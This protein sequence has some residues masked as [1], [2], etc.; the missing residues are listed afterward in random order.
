MSQISQSVATNPSSGENVQSAVGSSSTSE[1]A[2]N[3]F[4]VLQQDPGNSD[5]GKKLDYLSN[6]IS[7]MNT[8]LLEV[9]N[10]LQFSQA[11][12]AE[13]KEAISQLQRDV[14]TNTSKISDLQKELTCERKERLKL[15]ERV[16]HLEAQSRRDNLLFDGVP[17]PE[18][19]T[20]T[21]CL[22]T[23]FH[24]L[25]HN[26]SIPDARQMKIVRCHRNGPKIPGSTRPRQI[27]FKMFWFGDREKIWQSRRKLKGS[28]IWV[29]EDFPKEIVQRRYKLQP[30][31]REAKQ[32]KKSAFISVDKLIVEGR[33]YTVDTLSSL[34][35]ELQPQNVS[36]KSNGSITAFYTSASPLS[37]FYP[38]PVK[39]DESGITF[40]TSEHF[41]QYCKAKEFGDV[42][43][44][45]KIKMAK[46]PLEAY[47]LGRKV[48]NY[49]RSQWEALSPDVMFRVCKAKYLQ[50][51]QLR[52]FLSKTGD[53]E[54]VEASPFDL[55]WGVGISLRNL[56][57][58]FQ[59]DNWKGKNWMGKVLSKVREQL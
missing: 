31:L 11:E 55:F 45:D 23:V 44:M 34:P 19:E 1:E 42:E 8:L 47:R 43:S 7:G 16:I 36:T 54:L 46:S 26:M 35:S 53:T 4:T 52:D 58:L 49:N 14:T 2:T 9:R 41:Y 28:K 30:I 57:S 10:S 17:E 21:D 56:N 27:I 6:M 25:Q 29:S 40:N 32:L 13:A 3:V 12:L 33:T 59:K 5:L 48:S 37:N 24:I 38:S 20:P 39:D 22:N 50:H 15:E 18:G 51:P